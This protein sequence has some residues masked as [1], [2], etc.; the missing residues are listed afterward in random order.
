MIVVGSGVIGME[1]ASMF[2]II[3]GSRVTVIDER[4]D[5]LPFADREVIEALMH[6][7]RQEGA[8]FLLGEKLSSVTCTQD[9]RSRTGDRVEVKLNSGKKIVG[10]AL[11]WA[12]GRQGNTDTLSL[13]SCGLQVTNRGLLQVNES[14]QTSVPHIYAA[15]DCI[16]FPA[17]ASTAMEQGR[18]ASCHM[19]GDSESYHPMDS[20]F[21]YGIYTV[22]EISM[23][24]K[25]EQELTAA[26]IPY[27]VGKATFEELAKGQMLGGGFG[28]LKILFDPTTRKLLGVHCIG[29]GAT[30]IIHIGQVCTLSG[31]LALF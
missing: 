23:V 11:L 7:M 24:G 1:Y 27:E 10:D 28:F 12:V 30:E 2:T 25:S 9:A 31:R 29:E 4:P 6:Q 26:K 22:P 8:R 15:G 5:I 14:F 19:W 20:N 3:P 16:G 17:L 13:E 18:L 21:P